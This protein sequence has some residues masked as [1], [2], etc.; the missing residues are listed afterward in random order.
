VKR[1]TFLKGAAGVGAGAMSF[2]VLSGGCTAGAGRERAYAGQAG[3]V[4]VLKRLENKYISLALHSDASAD[5]FDKRTQTHWRMGAVALQETGPIDEGHVWL[6]TSR[7]ICEQYPGRFSG[8]KTGE[9]VR[10]VLLGRQSRPMG[11]FVLDVRLDGEWLE[12]VISDIDERLDSLIFP[13]SIESEGLVFPSKL[14]RLVRRPT[15]GRYFW[16]FFS[17]LN[18]RWFGGLKADAGRY[19]PGW[20]AIFTREFADAGVSH[21][22]LSAS[23]GWLKSLG[24]WRYPRTIRYRFTQDGYVGMAKAFRVW[25]IENGLHKSIEE[26]KAQVP[27][28]GNLS[29]GRFLSIVQACPPVGRRYFEDRLK[30]Y[31][32]KM[33]RARPI[34][35]ISHRQAAAIIKEAQRLGMKHGLALLRGWINGGYDYPHPDV[36]PPEPALGG[37]DELKAACSMAGPVAVGLHDNYQDI[38]EH[39]KSFPKGVIRMAN[40]QLMPGGYWAGG[41]AYIINPRDGIE[42]AKRNWRKIKTLRPAAMFIDTTTVV[43]PYE[44]YEKGNTLTRSQDIACKRQL[45]E[46]FKDQKVVLGSEGGSDFGMAYVDF[47]ENWHHRTPGESIPL[48]PIVYGDAAFCAR[49]RDNNFCIV[50]NYTQT[51][52]PWWLEDM[53][54]GYMPYFGIDCTCEWE[55]RKAEFKSTLHVDAWHGRVGGRQMVNHRFLADDFA[56]EQTTFANGLSIIVNFDRAE[57]LIEG[58]GVPGYGYV[59]EG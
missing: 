46:F 52:W 39:C 29:A 25:A 13:P 3:E 16:T 49:L 58:T 22:E 10:F 42:Y 1:R 6:R 23:P 47:F 41:Q 38:Y 12:F 54:W 30:P 50:M 36:W 44:S 35:N 17:H 20:M 21:T 43:Q 27:A 26:K 57:R 40:G 7:S 4:K 51:A 34:A 56:V 59:I 2:G 9:S 5:L 53:L 28:V 11:T 48:W 15:Q 33:L 31:N 32:E 55:K 14:G 8:R 24:R 45:L 18:M 37:I 19:G